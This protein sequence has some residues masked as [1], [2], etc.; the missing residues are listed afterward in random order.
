MTLM[1]AKFVLDELFYYLIIDRLPDKIIIWYN[2]AHGEQRGRAKGN[3]MGYDDGTKINRGETYRIL[4][5]FGFNALVIKA[6]IKLTNNLHCSMQQRYLRDYRCFVFNNLL[7]FQLC[8][9]FC[10]SSK[11]R[12][13]LYHSKFLKSRF[14]LFF[15]LIYEWVLSSTIEG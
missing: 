3:I 9:T 6:I 13:H 1:T 2:K 10:Q 4:I 7:C 14:L 8:V 15:L 11:L 12:R 5:T